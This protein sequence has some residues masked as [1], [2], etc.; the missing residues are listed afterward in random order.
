MVATLKTHSSGATVPE[1]AVAPASSASA[2]ASAVPSG[3][4]VPDRF[5]AFA[6]AAADLLV[7]TDLNGIISFA[8]GA[9]RSRLSAEARDY[10]GKPL[11]AL[12]VPADASDLVQALETVS[13]R[14]RIRPMILRLADAEASPASV[15]ALRR[16]ERVRVHAVGHQATNVHILS[17]HNPHVN[18]ARYRPHRYRAMAMQPRMIHPAV[19]RHPRR[20]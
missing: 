17:H 14:G 12:F 8:A 4:L 7:E 2:A 15:A 9:F 20:R 5:L 3:G 18:F 10:V 13:L 1:A 11:S 19:H 6:F 16:G